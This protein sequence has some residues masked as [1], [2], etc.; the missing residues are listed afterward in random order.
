MLI[1]FIYYILFKK[2][3]KTLK[4]AIYLIYKGRLSKIRN[5]LIHIVLLYFRQEIIW[6]FMKLYLNNIIFLNLLQ[7]KYLFLKITK[8]LKNKFNIY[9]Q[10]KFLL[11]PFNKFYSILIF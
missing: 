3:A 6:I 8:K 11:K 7:L 10:Q 9:T 1:I 4:Y 5:K 2:T